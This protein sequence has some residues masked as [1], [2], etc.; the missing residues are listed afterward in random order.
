MADAYEALNN[1]IKNGYSNNEAKMNNFEGIKNNNE[2]IATPGP[3]LYN[4]DMTS[5]WN[6]KSFNILFMNK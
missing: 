3:G 2:K 5:S 4:I 1:G 6:K